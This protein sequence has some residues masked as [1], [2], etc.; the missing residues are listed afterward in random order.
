MSSLPPQPLNL[1][2]SSIKFVEEA[3]GLKGKTCLNILRKWEA[4]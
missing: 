4:E 2:N 3:G 1:L